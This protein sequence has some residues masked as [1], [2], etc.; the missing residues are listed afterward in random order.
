MS[1]ET[2]KQRLLGKLAR[3]VAYTGP[4]FAIIVGA[5][6]FNVSAAE[7]NL[8]AN[9]LMVAAGEAEAEGKAKG[10]GEAEAKAKGEGEAEGKAE[11]EGEG[12]A[13]GEAEGKAKG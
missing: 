12:K 9:Y 6:A 2:Q 10:E 11:G 7:T 8:D 13:E 5:S 1:K 4:V 3:G